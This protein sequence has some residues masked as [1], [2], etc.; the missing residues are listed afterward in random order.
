MGDE[1]ERFQGTMTMIDHGDRSSMQC[2]NDDR[3]HGTGW[4]WNTQMMMVYI[5]TEG[6][7]MFMIM[8]NHGKERQIMRD[9]KALGSS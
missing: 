1:K 4:Q 3:G 7:A 8:V 5:G 6:N 9:D 2:E